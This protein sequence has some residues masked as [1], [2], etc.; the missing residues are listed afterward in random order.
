MV[1]CSNQEASGEVCGAMANPA[2]VGGLV[3]LV[4]IECSAIYGTQP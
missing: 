2:K 1:M 3:F 4:S